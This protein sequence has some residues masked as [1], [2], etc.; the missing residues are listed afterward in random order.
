MTPRQKHFVEEY[1]IC[2]K[3]THAALR[4]GY[5]PKTA[6]HSAWRLLRQPEVR[7]E[8][9]ARLALV[10]KKMLPEQDSVIDQL[11]QVA[12]A[13]IDDGNSSV[14]VAEKLRALELL[15]RHLGMFGG[16]K[17]TDTSVDASLGTEN[18]AERLR[19]ARLRL[20]R[21]RQ[22]DLKKLQPLDHFSVSDG[23]LTT[24]SS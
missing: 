12:F 5:S 20:E 17:A 24:L 1:L 16:A 8:I 18:L 3:A 14:K 2:R 19:N 15:G 9:D 13:P 4:A 21:M 22:E 6:K 11:A 10:Q 7:S 23:N